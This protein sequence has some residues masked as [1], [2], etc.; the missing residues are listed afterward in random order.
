MGSSS[1]SLTLGTG[2]LPKLSGCQMG[3]VCSG[4]TRF[5]EAYISDLRREYPALTSPQADG[6]DVQRG[7]TIE[8]VCMASLG[9]SSAS[10]S[11]FSWDMRHFFHNFH[12][13]HC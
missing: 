6:L 12:S 11:T 3:P 7:W 4:S 9:S 1:G 10:V 13:L 8:P 2:T 5:H